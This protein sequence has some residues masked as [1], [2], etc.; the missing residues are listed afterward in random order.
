MMAARTAS[1]FPRATEIPEAFRLGTPR[2]QR[3]FLCG[4]ELRPWSGPLQDVL[5]PVCLSTD[6][7]L[8]QQRIGGYPM[9]GEK[10]AL[11]ALDAASS[12]WASGRGAW[13][14]M[15]VEERIHH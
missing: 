11:E 10:E 13:P 2:E 8:V 14:T 1:I 4:G 9:L 6:A 5:S 12:A 7:G 3:V 15:T